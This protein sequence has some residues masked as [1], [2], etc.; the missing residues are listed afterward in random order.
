[1]IWLLAI[2]ILGGGFISYMGHKSGHRIGVIYTK[3]ERIAIVFIWPFL[4]VI[5]IVQA[6]WYS[7]WKARYYITQFI[8]NLRQRNAM[9]NSIE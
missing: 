3:W 7:T 2:W 1:M 9:N 4:A 5:S 8:N 6:I